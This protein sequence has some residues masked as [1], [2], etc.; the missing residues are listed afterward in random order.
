MRRPLRAALGALGTLGLAAWWLVERDLEPAPLISRYGNDA[1]RFVRL[2]SGQLVHFR[3]EGR[4]EDPPLLLIH[5]WQASLHTW[6]AWVERLGDEFRLLRLDLPGHGLTGPTPDG[7]YSPQILVDTVLALLDALGIDRCH[8][9]GS[10]M[11]GLVAWELAAT[12][13]ERVDRL[14]LI[15]AAGYPH[16]GFEQVA[17]MARSFWVRPLRWCS[18]RW[19]VAAVLHRVFHRSD[20]FV[21]DTM[22]DRHHD[23]IRRRG[24]RQ[25]NLRLLAADYDYRSTRQRIRSIQA[26]TLILWGQHDPWVSV[27]DAL[28]F[29]A[30]LPDSVLRIYPHAGHLPMEEEA[31]SSAAD[32]RDFLHDRPLA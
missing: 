25:A 10:S 18:P 1:S 27:Q 13:A 22:I 3:D 15:D 5:G 23:L 16:P 12:A 6:D 32:V 29:H 28:Q 9:A 7:V 14:I 8:I 24:N 30:D 4:P 19:L 20:E 2:P 17:A 31:D 21:D 26:P 11:G